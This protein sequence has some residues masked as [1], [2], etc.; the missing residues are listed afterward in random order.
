TPALR[1]AAEP[2][3]LSPREREIVTLLAAGLTNREIGDR[4]VLSVRTIEGH[5]YRAMARTG[6]ASRD[7]LAALM[8]RLR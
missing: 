8:E 2:L 1:N 5:I 4:L 3:P 7:E 6:M